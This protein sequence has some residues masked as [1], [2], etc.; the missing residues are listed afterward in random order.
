[1]VFIYSMLEDKFDRP[2]LMSLYTSLH[3]KCPPPILFI[4]SMPENK[5]DRSMVMSFL[6][7]TA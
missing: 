6:D 3:I 4:Y 2:M 7:L 5:F 1:M